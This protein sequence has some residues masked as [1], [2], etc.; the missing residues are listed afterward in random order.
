VVYHYT[1]IGQYSDQSL[2]FM[3]NKTPAD[4][5]HKDVSLHLF[6]MHRSGRY[7]YVNKLEL[8]RKPYRERQPDADANPRPVW[9]Y[10]LQVSKDTKEL[11]RKAP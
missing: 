7:M 11:P 1:G 6:E 4:S 9:V 5:R 10:P 3:Q 8:A 2:E